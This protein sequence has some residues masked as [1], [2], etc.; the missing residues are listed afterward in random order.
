M[1][2]LRSWFAL[3]AWI[4][5]ALWLGMWLVVGLGVGFGVGEVWWICGGGCGGGGSVFN[6]WDWD[7]ELGLG[8]LWG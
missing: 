1:P 7:N 5:V 2:R 8:R 6:Y 3:G 4:D